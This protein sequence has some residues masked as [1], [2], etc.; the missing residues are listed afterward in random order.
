MYQSDGLL[1][2]WANTTHKPLAGH[3][4]FCDTG[5]RTARKAVRFAAGEWNDGAYV[6]Q[7]I[8]ATAEKPVLTLGGVPIAFVPQRRT[9]IRLPQQTPAC[10]LSRGR[11]LI[12]S[13]TKLA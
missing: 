7:L 11:S 12:N 3:V 9:S 2:D 8:I 4:T 10:K 13:A 1:L 6:C 5:R